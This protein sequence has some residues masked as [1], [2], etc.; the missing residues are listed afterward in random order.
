MDRTKYSA[1]I[2]QDMASATE[3]TV[4]SS[5]LANDPEVTVTAPSQTNVDIPETVVKT[6]DPM[7]AVPKLPKTKVKA[8]LPRE[9]NSI[10]KE[11]ATSSEDK[12]CTSKLIIIKPKSLKVFSFL[13]H[14]PQSASSRVQY[15]GIDFCGMEDA[16][17]SMQ[18]HS[19]S[20]W[21]FSQMKFGPASILSIH[22]RHGAKLPLYIA[23][24]IGRRLNN[25]Y[26]SMIGIL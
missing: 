1:K 26:G 12:K 8:G 22:D 23:R 25:R 2:Q 7:N 19:G 11:L 10:I 14:D 15:L 20:T 9:N 4:T 17:F 24:G 18:K 16:G 6:V 5:G 21:L 13:F 3:V